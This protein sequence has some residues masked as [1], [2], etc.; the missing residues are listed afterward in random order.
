MAQGDRA[1]AG[2]MTRPE[3]GWCNDRNP[4]NSGRRLSTG[5]RSGEMGDSLQVG[6]SCEGK[7]GRK[8]GRRKQRELNS[9]VERPSCISHILPETDKDFMHGGPQS[10]QRPPSI[11]PVIFNARR[12]QLRSQLQKRPS[13]KASCRGIRP[14]PPLPE[15]TRSNRFIAL[16]SPGIDA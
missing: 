9:G 12:G 6:R 11:H 10:G 1:L 14:P 4:E 8:E 3:S 5:R 7:E 16:S 13:S 15:P 2:L